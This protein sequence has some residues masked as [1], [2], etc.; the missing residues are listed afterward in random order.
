[1]LNSYKPYQSFV[2]RITFFAVIAAFVLIFLAPGKGFAAS[3]NTESE[4][5]VWTIVLAPVVDY[6]IF[7]E[8]SFDVRSK[9]EPRGLSPMQ[10]PP[11]EIQEEGSNDPKPMKPHDRPG[12]PVDPAFLDQPLACTAPVIDASTTAGN[13]DE[14]FVVVNPNNTQNIVVFSNLDAN[15]IHRS[16]TTNGGTSWT[17]GT[18]ATNVAC[19]DAQAAWDNFG[20][21]FMVYISATGGQI[22]I[23]NS[24]DGGA[25]FSAPVTAGSSGSTDQP[26]IAV[27]NGSVW[28]DWN[29]GG[30][31]VAR[32]APVTGLGAWGP[33]IAQQTIPTAAGS[34]GGIA[35]GPGANGG[36]VIVTYMSPTGGQGPATIYTNTD[37]DGLGA[38]GFGA[39]VT[40][41]TTNVGGFDFIPAQS[42]RSID[43]EPGVVW[44]ATGGA[45][46][47][48]I[49]L[50]YTE[51]IV[52]ESNDTDILMRTSDNDGATWSAPVRVNDDA[53]TRSQFLPYVALDRST[54]TVAVGF[55]DS[56]N[57]NGTVGTGGTN[58]T[59]N[60]DAE[61]WATYTTNGG[62]S[63]AVNTRISGGWS[64]AAAAGAGVDYG[65]YEG[66]AAQGGKFYAVWGDNS[67]C[68]GLN[69]NGTAHQFDLV[70]GTLTFTGGSTPTSTSTST[71]TSTATNTPTPINTATATNT[72]VNTATSS[73]T[74]TATPAISPTSTATATATPAGSLSV[75]LPVS[76]AT[77]GSE[78][79]VP[80]TVGD[81]TGQNITS[82]D[83]QI[84]FDP[85]VL[86][87]A[88]T[89]FDIA[90]TLSSSMAITPNLNNS[91]HFVV[92][93]FQTTSIAGSGTLINLRFV[94]V[95]TSGQT[96]MLTFED[97]TD[98]GS[99]FHP[100]F[101]FNEG[102]PASS[103][104][105]GSVSAVGTTISGTI[106]YGNPGGAPT[107]RFVSSVTVAGA[108]SPGVMTTSAGIGPVEG[109]YWLSGFGAGAY[110][111]MPTKTGG[112]NGAINS[113]D[114]A[115]IAQH[116][117][118]ISFLTGTQTQV[119]DVSNN[120]SITSFDAAVIANY[121]VGGAQTGITGTWKFNPLN[122]SYPSVSSS[123]S[124]ENYLALL[125]GE[126]SGNWSN[127]GARP[128]ESSGAAIAV[129]LP[130]PIAS[131]D[132][133]VVVP[134]EVQGV[135]NRGIISCEFEI[136]FDPAILQP[137]EDPF[138]VAGTVGAGLITL[139]NAD[140]PGILRIVMY[141]A[142]PIDN[143][144]VL[145]KLKFNTVGSSGSISPI[146]FERI[147]FNEDEIRTTTTGGQVEVST[148]VN[149]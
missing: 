136:R 95:G 57:D 23:I 17:H 88:A 109:Q 127:T 75:S 104:G 48:R 35:V 72:P 103:T 141:G 36:K 21:L 54:G 110:T 5:S 13:E 78:I 30:N 43:A 69:P 74:N 122:R 97:Y 118:G 132:N 71:P 147:I 142:M 100:G 31:M 101:M 25:T 63:F 128:A 9:P 64:N 6:G 117:A 105:Y 144:G 8:R 146:I 92:S 38:G 106:T 24:T 135:A 49:Y 90:G 123:V 93:A 116:V 70:M 130:G 129:S 15:S 126:V 45:F 44:D 87:P 113:F 68:N 62:V 60:D 120:G 73:A 79:T 125:M 2:G 42:A 82:Y 108:G 50:V 94:V 46:N 149:N 22:N 34:F 121:V 107:P 85:A 47:N 99:T 119:A 10:T 96:S 76:A 114:A 137:Q 1:M 41:T 77:P 81:T 56:R 124:G 16:Y 112:Q 66:Q 39:R 89:P 115:R 86:V 53:T 111:V 3:L 98:P 18:V 67:N 134:V 65:D 102:K 32:G 37:A 140:E 139:A 58:A 27:G 59:A 61:Y 40:V 133:E 145:L 84:T 14:S 4:A 51:E 55:H 26:S 19:C 131:A 20:N 52:N 143:D 83:L 7:P 12:I 33:F 148:A 11:P 29:T 80:I 28:V 138:D 91:G